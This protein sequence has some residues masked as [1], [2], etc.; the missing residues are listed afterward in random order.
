MTPRH[1]ML[2]RAAG[3]RREPTEPEHRLWRALSGSKLNGLKFRRQATIGDRIVDF[4]SGKGVG[5]R[6]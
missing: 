2:D 6:D 3:M 5:C 1:V 4:F